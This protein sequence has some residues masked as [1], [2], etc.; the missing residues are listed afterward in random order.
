MLEELSRPYGCYGIK[1][2]DGFSM[3]LDSFLT[4]TED[5]L[6]FSE[7]QMVANISTRHMALWSK[8]VFNYER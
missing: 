4:H 3:W 1:T 2:L 5:E 6:S 7:V 8:E